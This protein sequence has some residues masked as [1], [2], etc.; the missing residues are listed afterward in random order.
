M[1]MRTVNPS[2]WSLFISLVSV[3][4]LLLLPV[5]HTAD[6]TNGRIM[7]GE[8]AVP[9]R[10]GYM[11]SL[12][13]IPYRL[14]HDCGG[15][16]IA[17]DVVL[18]A[19]HCV[20][21][22]DDQFNYAV[23]T[24][25]Y[26]LSQP[27]EGSEIFPIAE[28]VIHPEYDSFALQNDVALIKLDGASMNRPL[29]V[30]NQNPNLPFVDQSLTQTGWGDTSNGFGS[31]PDILQVFE[32][33]TYVDLDTCRALDAESSSPIGD[34]GDDVLCTIEPEASGVCF[35]DSG[36]CL[37]MGLVHHTHTRLFS[38]AVNQSVGRSASLSVFGCPSQL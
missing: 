19:A 4:L 3:L 15:T 22:P 26:Q 9:G 25:P 23:R 12:Q 36:A 33:A 31:Y 18:T 11:V 1:E 13:V 27:S 24:G 20:E 6:A 29:A 21:Y 8:N 38:V 5:A 17:P 16:L 35:G 34:I 2:V 7:G 32:G 14:S 30:L 10:Y 28:I 37:V